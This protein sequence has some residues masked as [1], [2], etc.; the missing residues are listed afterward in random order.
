MQSK[1]H[2]CIFGRVASS[3]ILAKEYL[4]S[5]LRGRHSER[6][7]DFSS[8]SDAVFKGRALA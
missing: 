6:N 5:A 8:L 3:I 4:M 1:V 7:A 2:V